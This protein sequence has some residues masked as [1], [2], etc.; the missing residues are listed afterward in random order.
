MP[1]RFRK[2][3]KSTTTGKRIK[4]I[5]VLR[6]RFLKTILECFALPVEYRKMI[7]STGGILLGRFDTRSQEPRRLVDINLKKHK[8]V[9]MKNNSRTNHHSSLRRANQSVHKVKT[10]I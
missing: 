10:Q 9:G 6:E 7:Q 1:P 2:G 8:L 3:L 4:L 5:F